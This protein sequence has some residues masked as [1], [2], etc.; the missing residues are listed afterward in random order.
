MKVLFVSWEIDPFFKLGGLGDVARSLPAAL[1]KAGVDIKIVIPYYDV[2]RLGNNKKTLVGNFN[3]TYDK[4]NEIV[5]IYE[6]LHPTSKVPVYLLKNKKYLNKIKAADTFAF[7]DKA[8]VEMIKRNVTGW[9]PE[10]VHCND[11]HAGLIPLLIK[12]E[13]L[14]IKTLFTIHNLSYQGEYQI[15]LLDKLEMNL[16]RCKVVKWEIRTKKINFLTEGIIH[17]DFVTTVSPTYAKEIMKEE[18]GKGLEEILRAREGRIFGILNG[19]DIEYNNLLHNKM[20]SYPYL[21]R[22]NNA[23]EKLKLKNVSWEEGKKLNKIYLQKKLGLSIG[24]SIPI[25]GFIG[26]FDAAQKGIDLIHKM[27]R[28]NDKLDFELVVLGT[29]DLNWEER[30]KWLSKFYPKNVSCNFVFDEKLARQIY[31]ASDF[32]L[33]PSKFEPCG[34]VQMI[35]MSYGTLPIAYK[36]GGLKDSIKDGIN[37]FLFEKITSEALE[38]KVKTAID[39]WKNN[40]PVYKKMVEEAMRTDFSWDKSATEFISLYEKALTEKEL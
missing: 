32:M 14:P 23:D 9:I 13:K 33:I 12:E 24:N 36:T 17:A 16:S 15:D 35:S 7:F 8:I 31:A 2:L 27:V 5:K 10:I 3:V 25:L 34:L 4:K 21:G 11:H 26:R 40:K 19:I 22:F 1:K 37:G 38:R 6:V 29:G 20:L 18:Y 28:R 39:I 30:Y